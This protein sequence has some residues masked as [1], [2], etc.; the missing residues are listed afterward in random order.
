MRSS[1]GKIYFDKIFLP[2]FAS[3]TQTFF[4]YIKQ[5]DLFFCASVLVHILLGE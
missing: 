2:V 1:N 5:I 3:F 4:Y